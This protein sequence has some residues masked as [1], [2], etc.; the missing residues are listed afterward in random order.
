V[1]SI[2]IVYVAK[3]DVLY[4]RFD[5]QKQEVIT[6]QRCCS[7]PIGFRISLLCGSIGDLIYRHV[8]AQDRGEGIVHPGL[9]EAKGIIGE[10]GRLVGKAPPK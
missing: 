5:D 1:A 6:D 4:V 8:T 9:E 3:I 2:Q 7:R 10:V